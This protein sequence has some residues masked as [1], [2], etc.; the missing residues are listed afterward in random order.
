MLTADTIF[1]RFETL[2]DEE[3]VALRVLDGQRV[4]AIADEK[5]ELIEQLQQTDV[6]ER[7]DLTPR[8]RDLSASLR[9][10]AVLLAHARDCLRDVLS[11]I[12]G[13][14]PGA[15]ATYAAPS[16]RLSLRG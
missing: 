10:N 6:T 13:A 5:T 1:D 15:S 12:H 3:R 16:A 4:S 2:L 8:L 9:R 7:A 11:V 14:P